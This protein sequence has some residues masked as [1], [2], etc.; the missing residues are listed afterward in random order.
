MPCKGG[1]FV[2]T[3]PN[4]AYATHKITEGERNC[5][6]CSAAGAV[7]LIHGR[8]LWDVD[9]IAEG[10]IT[11]ERMVSFKNG[12]KDQAEKITLVVESLTDRHA[13][14]F[15]GD[16]D[17]KPYAEAIQWMQNQPE[18]TVFVVYVSGPLASG[19]NNR[20]H[21]LNALK[22]GTIRFF[23]FQT[24]RPFS[25]N[26]ADNREQ[27]WGGANPSSSTVPFVGIVTQNVAREFDLKNKNNVPETLHSH[28]Q[29]GTLDTSKTKC[30]VIAFPPKQL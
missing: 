19:G 16:A 13:A 23:D 3:K 9:R 26:S 8:S 10:P 18:L 2:N 21:W 27:T 6:R 5:G 11:I 17:E 7:N 28:Q 29:Q 30:V 24:N 12:I 22:A 20:S 4:S 15:G 14:Q 25:S 1:P